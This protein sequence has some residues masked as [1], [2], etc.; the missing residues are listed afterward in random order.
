MPA[1]LVEQ[2]GKNREFLEQLLNTS[3]I[4]NYTVPVA[5]KADLRKYQQVGV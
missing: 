4:D 1:S 5:I 2:R 3:K